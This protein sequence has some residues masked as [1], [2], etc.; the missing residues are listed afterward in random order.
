MSGLDELP[1]DSSSSDDNS[2]VTSSKSA[3]AKSV[4]L[5]K[6]RTMTPK[7]WEKTKARQASFS[8][9]LTDSKE[10]RKLESDKRLERN[11]KRQ[12]E[13]DE[14][15]SKRAEASVAAIR[16]QDKEKTFVKLT[17][18]YATRRALQQGTQNIH[19]LLDKALDELEDLALAQRL[20]TL[21]R[22]LDNANLDILRKDREIE[23]FLDAVEVIKHIEEAMTFQQEV[24]AMEEL[25]RHHMVT[26]YNNNP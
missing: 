21:K 6:R 20:N 4:P 1:T 3:P 22:I 13:K 12:E 26:F 16:G 10:K 24:Y 19:G 7:A 23:E 15:E 18:L 17:K 14:A 5:V 9:M 2:P 25:L 11:V 8:Q